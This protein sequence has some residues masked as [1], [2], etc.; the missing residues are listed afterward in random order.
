MNVLPHVLKSSNVHLYADDV[1][2]YSNY[3]RNEITQAISD[4]NNDLD[5]LFKWTSGNELSLN[6]SKS[7]C[8]VISRNKI[9]NRFQTLY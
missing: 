2:L 1:Q 4:I 6:P 5:Q 8:I 3:S 7:R 9:E